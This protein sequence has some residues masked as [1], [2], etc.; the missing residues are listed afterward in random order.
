MTSPKIHPV[1]MQLSRAKG[2]R[3]VSPNGLPIVSVARPSR[4]GNVWRVRKHGSTWS[5][6]RPDSC[7]EYTFASR[8]TALTECLALFR[9]DLLSGASD[10]SVGEV[11]EFLA[12]KNLACWCKLGEPCHADTLLCVARGV[13]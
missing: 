10:V 7:I 8:S 13:Y 11:R 4:W 6:Y 12:E 5:V 1:R 9:A 2:A 3:L